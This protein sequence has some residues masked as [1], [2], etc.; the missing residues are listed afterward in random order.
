M[1]TSCICGLII[2]AILLRSEIMAN[3]DGWL[4]DYVPSPD[5]TFEARLTAQEMQRSN[6]FEIYTSG[7]G[8]ASACIGAL[9][10]SIK[11]LYGE[12][13]CAQT[14]FCLHNY[15][16]DES[17][18]RAIGANWHLYSNAELERSRIDYLGAFNIDLT[19]I[20]EFVQ[21]DC[22]AL[23]A[24]WDLNADDSDNFELIAVQSRPFTVSHTN[25]ISVPY[26]AR[27]SPNM[28]RH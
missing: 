23:I 10:D 20:L 11:L 14:R 8:Y 22:S 12:D 16:Q 6:L 2:S 9:M 3:H 26:F 18:S 4:G 17:T 13:V 25:T 27:C 28:N 15:L 1:L 5:D 24:L 7:S 21:I 19:D